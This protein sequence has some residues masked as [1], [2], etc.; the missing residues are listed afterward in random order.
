M[1]T[2]IAERDGPIMHLTLN[3]PETL[4]ALDFEM[5]DTL[6]A[7]LLEAEGDRALRA[8]ILTGAGERAFSAGADI[9][10]LAASIAKGTEAAMVEIVARGQ[11]LTRTIETLTKPVI[12]A[13]NGIA[14]G[15]GCEVTEAAPLAIASDRA[16]FAKPEIR[17]GFP[18]PFGGS[19]RL[20]RHVGRKR[21]LEMILTGAPIDAERAAA[22]GLV[23]R[24][25]PH[26]RLIEEARRL[27]DAIIVHTP[28]AVTACLAAVTRGIE[29]PIEEGLAMEASWFAGLAES[30][31]VRDGL[32]RFLAAHPDRRIEGRPRAPADLAPRG[33]TDA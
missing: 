9:A 19:Q 15:G 14:Y 29:V 13:V 6:T 26:G 1:P 20:P 22:I 7:H 2:V 31:G 17:L 11:G 8:I 33:R 30:D 18:P 28:A 3:R 24:V 23:N 21:G 10:D 12:V 32:H 4:N 25:V 16:L 5:I 27:A